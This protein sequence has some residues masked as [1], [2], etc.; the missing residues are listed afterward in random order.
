MTDSSPSKW[1]ERIEGEWHG[2]PSI[3]EAN[4]NHAG[5]TKVYR[6]SVFD[7]GKTTYYM[8][9]HFEAQGE[10]R[11]RLEYA[12]FAF[13]VL[14]SDQDRIYMGPDFYGAGRPF[15]A[16]VD[17]HYYSPGW[18][19][20]LR[21]MVHV[22]PDG[23]T[24]IYSSLLYNGPSIYC[25]F[26]GIYKVA[27]D[28]HTNPETQARIGAFVETEIANGPRPH[29]LPAKTAGRW[30]GQME[31]YDNTQQCVG[32][33]NVE[34]VYKP[35][36]LLRA[37]QTVTISGVMNRKYSFTRHR[38][39]NLHAY[40]GPDIYGNAIG[41]GRALYTTQHFMGEAFKI[42]GREFLIDDQ[43]TMSAVWQFYK[44]DTM[45][46]TTFGLLNWEA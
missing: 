31:V 15:G 3:F 16:L 23:Q 28:Y 19:S 13:E 27:F 40:E 46:Y 42:K 34:I 44:S 14:D 22:L 35:L 32:V 26:N 6:S 4:G 9:T 38:N 43:N 36:S 12:D 11:A 30:T 2:R 41:Y 21:T 37:E 45:Q 20:D 24:Q 1:Q 25:V 17:A 7:G 18:V 10:L 29:V 33:N 8:D 39:N 5:Y